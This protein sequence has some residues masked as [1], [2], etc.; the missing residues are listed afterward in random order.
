MVNYQVLFSDPFIFTKLA[1]SKAILCGNGA[2]GQAWA[3]VRATWQAPVGVLSAEHC[4]QP[5]RHQKVQFSF[6][7]VQFQAMR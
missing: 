2:Q 4:K 1:A 7:Q 6:V 3:A 5:H